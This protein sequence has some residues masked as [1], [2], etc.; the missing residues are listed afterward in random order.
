[1]FVSQPQ[2]ED[3]LERLQAGVQDPRHGLW[4]PGS[5]TWRV[6]RENVVFLGAGRAALLQLAH[7]YVA[8]AIEQH[9]ETQRDP[10]SRFNRTFVSMYAMIFGDVEQALSAAR[11][12]RGVHGRIAGPIDE[13]VGRFSA[14]HR[15]HAHE[16]GALLW[17]FATLVDTSLLA[18]EIGFGALSADQREQYYGEQK[19][20]AALFGLA[21]PFLPADLK[22]FRAYFDRTIE[23]DELSVG[24]PAGELGRF[25]MSS[26]GP[27]SVPLKV[28]L[29]AVTAGMLTPRLREEFGLPFGPL[30]R[31]L[32]RTALLG[33]SQASP[34]LP[35]RLRWRPEYIEARRRLSGRPRKDRVGR[36]LEQALLRVMRPG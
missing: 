27:L 12:V 19:K 8:H 16:A 15:Y 14:G 25:L 9:S 4:G 29:R 6:A 13:D 24:R 17:V 10:I 11:R 31:A 33:V 23:S 7:P 30:D 36:A 32:Y 18:Y 35:P 22:A 26:T 5:M 28:C 3:A 21:E 34:R 1:M 20:L 2:F